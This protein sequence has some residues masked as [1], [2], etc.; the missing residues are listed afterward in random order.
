MGTRFGHRT[1]RFG[2]ERGSVLVMTVVLLGALMVLAASFLRLGV[3][4]SHEHNSGVDESRAFYVAEAGVAEAGAAIL[5]GKSGNVATQAAPAKFANGILWVQST[6]LGGGDYQVDSTALCDSGRAAVR[7]VVHKENTIEYTQGVTSNL[8]LVVGSN[9]QIDSYDPAKGSY[10]SQPKV[11]LPGHNDWIV[12]TKGNIKSNGNILLSSNDRIYGDANPGPGGSISGLGGNTFV[13]GSTSPAQRPTAFP[14][15]QVPVLPSL[16]AKTIRRTDP[17][18]ARTLTA[19]SY[20]F[21]NLTIGN[22]AAFTIQGPSTVVLD[23]LTTNAGCNLNIDATNGPVNV[24]FTGTASFVSNMTVTSSAPSAKSI[25]L[26]FA[27]SNPVNLNPNATLLGTIY[28][29][30]ATVTVSSNWANF[31]AITANAVVLSSNATLHFDESLLTQGRQGAAVVSI[32]QWQRLAVP[33]SMTR[34]RIDPYKLLGL[35]PGSLLKSSDA[36]H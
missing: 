29:P 32:R 17:L 3:N 11:K 27:S 9:F 24:Y 12:G 30:A 5:S 35:A 36:Y 6:D 19:G 10:A 2:D 26:F 25:S 1:R 22:S 28:A 34:S 13:T 16:G 18:P 21:S 31:G 14:P 23:G 4:L 33:S 20:H 8:P 15:V 7:A